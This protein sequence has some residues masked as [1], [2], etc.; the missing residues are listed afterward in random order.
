MDSN[1]FK[2]FIEYGVVGILAFLYVMDARKRKKIEE[3][4]DTKRDKT[5]EDIIKEMMH[6]VFGTTEEEKGVITI[7][8]VLIDQ[9]TSYESKNVK[10]HAELKTILQEIQEDMTD[11]FALYQLNESNDKKIK[12]NK[13]K[14]RAKTAEVLELSANDNLSYFLFEFSNLFQEWLLDTM[15][16]LFEG[17]NTTDTEYVFNKIKSI[18]QQIQKTCDSMLGACVCKDLFK[19][20]N[21]DCKTLITDI[22]DIINSPGNDKVN[23]FFDTSINFLQKSLYKIIIIWNKYYK[24]EENEPSDINGLEKLR[25]FEERKTSN[26]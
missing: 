2:Y 11:L 9:L 17:E 6:K 4:R 1:F 23:R 14:L 20:E 5:N 12:R 22:D 8:R 19:P 13:S 18:F 24:T 26:L 3:L 16:Y 25:E 7:N 21:I 10:E 15:T